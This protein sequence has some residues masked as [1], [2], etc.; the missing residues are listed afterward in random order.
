MVLISCLN[1]HSDGT[2]RIQWWAC[3]VTLHFCKSVPM[4]KQPSWLAS[5][6][7]MYRWCV[8]FEKNVIFEWTILLTSILGEFFKSSA[9]HLENTWWSDHHH[10]RLGRH[11][12]T[13]H[14][15]TLIHFD[16]SQTTPTQMTNFHLFVPAGK[17]TFTPFWQRWIE[18][19][20]PKSFRV[21]SRCLRSA[22]L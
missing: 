13:F 5:R 9:M 3:N 6:C 15:L 11:M 19:W 8:H 17:R 7:V 4:K 12:A 16:V 22:T 21:A 2:Q 10:L 14:L 18:Q 1:S 20:A